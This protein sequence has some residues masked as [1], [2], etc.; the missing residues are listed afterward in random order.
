MPCESSLTVSRSGHRVASMRRRRSASSSSEKLMWNSRMASPP[1]AA[2]VADMCHSWCLG[3]P[4]QSMV[5]RAPPLRCQGDPHAW[6]QPNVKTNA[7]TPAS[8]NSIS[9]RR[10][11]IAPA[12]GRAGTSAGSRPCRCRPRRRR[13][14]GPSRVAARRGGPGSAPA[15][16]RPA[17]P[18][19]GGRRGRGTRTRWRRPASS[20]ARAPG[21]SASHPTSAHSLRRR[22]SGAE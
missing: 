2:S 1:V 12:G 14:R 21:R 9:K 22:A 10:S 13:R 6:R 5:P 18:S 11:S 15:G 17:D 20:G 3:V 8:R 4:P 7:S 19:R 16:G